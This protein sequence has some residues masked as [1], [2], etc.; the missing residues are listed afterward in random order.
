[1]IRTVRLE[2]G[3]AI[4]SAFDPLLQPTVSPSAAP[5]PLRTA[6]HSPVAHLPA[7]D[8]PVAGGVLLGVG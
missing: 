8:C 4:Y 2:T 1:M 3:R 5:L 6:T 7:G